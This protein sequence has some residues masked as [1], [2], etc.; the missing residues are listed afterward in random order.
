MSVLVVHLVR[1][2]NG[3]DALARFLDA[4]L[5]HPVAASHELLL[6]MKGF[7]G[8]EEPLRWCAEAQRRVAGVRCLTLPDD[9]L[10]LTAYARVVAQSPA[11]RYC[12]LNSHSRPLVDGWL[13]RLMGAL[14]VPGVGLAGA[15]GS[16][17][18]QQDYRRYHLGLRSGYDHVFAGREQT[19]QAFLALTRARN[20]AKRDN[21]RIAFK[22]AAAVDLVRDR[23][24]FA[25]FPAHHLRT[26][27]FAAPRQLLLDLRFPDIRSKR[28]AHRLESGAHSLT[29]QVE[30]IGRRVVVADRAGSVFDQRAWDRS[31]TLWQESQ[32]GLLVADNQTDDYES[33]DAT[34]RRVLAQLA[35][36]ARARPALYP[37]RR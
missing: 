6:A 35:W 11:Q 23:G 17:A 26:N 9:G 10:D 32:Q 16:W 22:A 21:G 24:A 37:L 34:R 33:G 27:A 4:Y 8:P 5:A 18:S 15:T 20:P 3:R 13:D 12:F 36:G 14:D 28:D 29:R 2:Q 19:R 25:P 7:D 1:R 30:A 31:A